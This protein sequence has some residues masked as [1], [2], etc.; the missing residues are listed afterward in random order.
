[1]HSNCGWLVEVSRRATVGKSQ[2][3][4]QEWHRVQG[5]LKQPWIGVT[6]VGALLVIASPSPLTTASTR[7]EH[8]AQSFQ[9]PG[10]VPAS[11]FR[12]PRQH[13]GIL[14]LHDASGL[15]FLLVSA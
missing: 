15:D 1:M 9:I 8:L 10:E 14:G 7:E 2:L 4:P 5:V 12:L 11:N 13:I 6:G 3:K